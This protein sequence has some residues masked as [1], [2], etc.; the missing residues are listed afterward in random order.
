MRMVIVK[1]VIACDMKSAEE[2]LHSKQKKILKLKL[3][4]ILV[5]ER[6][7]LCYEKQIF[8]LRS[9]SSGN[10]SECGQPKHCFLS[11]GFFLQTN[12]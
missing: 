12:R 1:K 2:R 8:E 7:Q 3:H 5:I 9:C 4:N 6:L 10:L 11:S